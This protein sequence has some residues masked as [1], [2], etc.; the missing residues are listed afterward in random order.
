VKVLETNSW[1]TT[2][3]YY[4]EKA[5][6]I[7]VFSINDLLSTIDILESKLD[8]FTGKVLETKTTHKKAEKADIIT[9]D[10]FEYDHTDRL[11]NQ[12]QK[13]NNQEEQVLV[14]NI[15]DELGQLKNKGV[16][17]KT[18]QNRLQIVDYKYNVRGWLK[19]INEDGLNDKDLFNFTINYNNPTS[20]GTGLFNGNISQ[21]SWNTLS[22]DKSAKM[23]NYRYDALNRITGA[24]EVLGDKYDVSGIR[25]DKNG[26]IRNLIR[27]GHLDN[28]T[29]P[30]FGEMD[31]LVYDYGT[32][33]G[34]KLL[35]VTDTGVAP[36]GVKGQFQD[37]NK[38]G[39]DYA[40]DLNGNMTSDKNKE[41]TNITYNH[42]NLPT[43]VTIDG[44]NIDYTYDAT[45]TKLKKVVNDKTTDYA[46]N[47]IYKNN[48]LQFLNHPEGYV[49]PV[50]TSDIS[51]GFKYVYQYKDHL[52]NV[53][54]SYTDNNNDGVIQTDGTNSEIVEESNYYPFGLKHKGYNNV[55]N[56]GIG[57]PTAQKFGFG[58]KELNDDLVGGSNLNW[59]DFGARNYDAALGRWMNL[60][61]LAEDMYTQSPYVYA[62]N[63]PILMV[64][65]DGKKPFPGPFTGRAYRQKN[66]IIITV[67][68]ITSEQRYATG[69][70]TQVA[71]AGTG[72]LGV[73][74][75]TIDAIVNPPTG[76]SAAN[77]A[78]ALT[79][80]GTAAAAEL[81]DGFVKGYYQGQALPGK[82]DVGHLRGVTNVF[83]K[84]PIKALGYVGLA[85]AVS[86][87]NTRA[88]EY[89]EK[90]TYDFGDAM[91]SGSNI[92][93]VNEGLF[94]VNDETST[95]ENVESRLNVIH[96]GVSLALKKYDLNTKKGRN[97][98]NKFLGDKQNR[99]LIMH[100]INALWG[101]HKKES[102]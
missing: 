34:N 45:G 61:P 54:L 47:Y 28:T 87:N 31:N 56:I 43:R 94:D 89:L 26:N 85:L 2:I 44:K 86:D 88:N 99:R 41:I 98:A 14:E 82:Y 46:G 73:G 36:I 81:F 58:G 39:N 79:P 27:R 59:H 101:K 90:A 72:W 49:S 42:L 7:Y 75:A 17:G 102:E 10:H 21:T 66:G 62:L 68:R 19:N 57:N 91:I 92:N 18:T 33:N 4:D 15:Y 3:T 53:R 50:N 77:T 65:P 51:Q 16:G 83:F 64:D 63:N 29:T 1:I 22:A 38:V 24:T 97:E 11:I 74:G 69:V 25:Y 60:D 5:R 37:K 35:K 55:R 13:I 84:G 48:M 95:E 9:V 76:N 8:A 40:Y 6:P 70:Y 52:G 71:Y 32:A 78:N 96:T 67:A 100:F 80:T 12:T 23:Y 93:I 20:T 30:L